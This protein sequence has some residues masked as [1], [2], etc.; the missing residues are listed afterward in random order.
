MLYFVSVSSDYL[1][2]IL[3]KMNKFLILH[4]SILFAVK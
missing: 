3:N 1:I 4:Y 2:N